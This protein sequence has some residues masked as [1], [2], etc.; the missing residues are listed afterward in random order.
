M[1]HNASIDKY[2]SPIGAIKTGEELTLRL[3]DTPVKT[4]AVSVLLFFEDRTQECPMTKMDGGYEFSFC[5]DNNP[6]IVWYFFKIYEDNHSYFYGARPGRSCGEGM[7]VGSDPF[8]F[9]ITVYDKNFHTPK[10]MQ[11]GVMYQIFP[12]RFARGNRENLLH[13][14]EYHENMG[15]EI[16]V[17]RNWEEQPLF[18]PIN[19]N[20]NYSPCDFFGGDLEGIIEHINEL[21]DMGVTCIYLNPIVEADSNHRYNTA[22]HKKLDPFLGDEDDFRR[23]CRHAKRKGIRI[24]L[25]GVY[26]HTGDDSIYFNKKGNYPEKGAFQ[27]PESPYYDWYF[28]DEEGSYK[29]WWGFQSLPEVDKTNQAYQEYIITGKNSVLNYWADLGSSGVRLDVADELTDEFIF[30][31]RNTMKRKNPDSAIIGEVWEDVTTKES[32]GVKRKYA[33]GKGLDSA[34]NYPFK[35][36]CSNYLLR[37]VNAY[38]MQEFL[39]GQQCNYPKPFYYANMNLLSSHDIPR[40]RTTLSTGLNENIPSRE[41]QIDYVIDRNMDNQGQ[42]LSRLAV[43]IQFFIPGIPSIYYGDEYGMHGFKDPFNRGTLFK[44]DTEIYKTYEKMAQF[45]KAEPVL[46]TGHA[47]FKAINE[48]VL[49]IIRFISDGHDALGEKAQDGAY[50]LI[51]NPTSQAE[52]VI[53]DLEQ[54]FEGVENHQYHRFLRKV[55]QNRISKVI[56]PFDYVI[57]KLY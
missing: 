57:E 21:S 2:R 46:Q 38:A 12:D 32:Y 13:G 39:L 30:M 52:N 17:H 25:D 26:S 9:Q 35:I 49:A 19:G 33:L 23:L 34:M 51:V 27:G 31:I 18:A 10:W 14:K 4:T 56:E 53:I 8:S 44:R 55:N 48:N 36:Q 15:R 42:T 1:I 28:F 20:E 29:S 6:Q 24:V 40:I 37:Y 45:R 16:Y 54:P 3:L 22:N 5:V 11:K 47:I 41:K 50:L 43:A 7:T